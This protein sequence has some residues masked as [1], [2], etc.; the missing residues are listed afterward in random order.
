MV[1]S[2]PLRSPEFERVF[3]LQKEL[4]SADLTI[5][6]LKNQFLSKDFSTLSD[7]ALVSNS[8]NPRIVA[9]DVLA[10]QSFLRK[11]KFHYIEQHAKDKYVKF[12]VSPDEPGIDA[13]INEQLKETNED[14]KR[15]LKEAKVHLTETYEKIRNKASLVDA[16][17]EHA[18]STTKEAATL[19]QQILDARL[20]LTRLRTAHPAPRLTL[21]AAKE[22]ADEQEDAMVTMDTT[23]Q[24]LNDRAEEVKNNVKANV[25]EVERL[26]IERAT[27]E[28]GLKRT[29][30]LEEDNRWPALNDWFSAAV[31][32]HRSLMSLESFE[33]PTD[34][35]LRLTYNLSKGRR[36]TIQ[37][38]FEPKSRQIA[39]GAIIN[40]DVDLDIQEL[41]GVHSACND[42]PGLVRSV[43]ARL[44][45]EL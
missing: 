7:S 43:L 31:S 42:V 16:A 39:Q 6:E 34:N 38:V 36:A 22:I 20:A 25:K 35:E 18:Q 2:V 4:E 9:P 13:E 45:T 37:L 8:T 24:E 33:T 5:V 30:R 28:D 23:L 32:L 21:A 27:I 26:K 1:D 12:I 11:L 17:Y 3:A 19:T 41:V 44:R 10:Q 14:R 29:W 15:L 40:S